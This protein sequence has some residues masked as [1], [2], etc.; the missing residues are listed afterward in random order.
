MG[1]QWSYAGLWIDSEYGHGHSKAKPKC[2]TYNSPQL[3]SEPEFTFDLMEV[4]AVGPKPCNPL[5]E[6]EATEEV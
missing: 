1:G 2:T 5:E 6:N 4:W 3:S